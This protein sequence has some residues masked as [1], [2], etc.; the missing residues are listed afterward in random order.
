MANGLLCTDFHHWSIQCNF[1]AEAIHVKGIDNDYA[2]TLSLATTVDELLQEGLRP[3]LQF[4][5]SLQEI[6]SPQ[7][8]KLYP[9]GAIERA[10]PRLQRF[11]SWLNG[12]QP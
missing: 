8:G 6:L 12:Q 11:T 5:S 4:K 7:P 1:Q 9:A 3:E 10:P 2:D